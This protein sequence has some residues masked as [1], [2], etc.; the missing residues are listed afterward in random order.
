[1][2]DDPKDKQEPQEPEPKAEPEPPRD[3]HPS[4]NEPTYLDSIIETEDKFKSR[5]R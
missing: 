2:C 1:M 3:E 4:R 5:P